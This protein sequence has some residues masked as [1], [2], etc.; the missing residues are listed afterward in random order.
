MMY[1]ALWDHM[2]HCTGT[3]LH[4]Y[5]YQRHITLPSSAHPASFAAAPG[6]DLVFFVTD[7]Q[8][9]AEGARFLG[10]SPENFEI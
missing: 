6:A 10:G 4:T 3:G 2:N 8:A 7:A 9:S 5:I 1:Y